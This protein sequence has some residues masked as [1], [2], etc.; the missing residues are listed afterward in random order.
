MVSPPRDTD[1]TV[2][3]IHGATLRPPAVERAYREVYLRE[4][5][6]LAAAFIAIVTFS[7]GVFAQGDFLF[8][9]TRQALVAALSARAGF[10]LVG[11]AAI[12]SL[13]R[14]RRFARVCVE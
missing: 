5:A 3:E 2:P 10:V 4:N 11:I 7:F 12:W 13:H 8:A 6:R 1:R 9:Q 14:T